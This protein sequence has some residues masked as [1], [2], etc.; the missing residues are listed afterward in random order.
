MIMQVIL[1]AN[2]QRFEMYVLHYYNKESSKYTSSTLEGLNHSQSILDYIKYMRIQTGKNWQHTLDV[3]TNNPLNVSLGYDN[4]NADWNQ[5][6]IEQK[7][8]TCMKERL[9]YQN[10][11]KI[12]RLNS[13][14]M[15]P[16]W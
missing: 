6:Q 16:H 3:S 10:R 2:D 11:T 8:I 7:Q 5:D 12:T 1:L 14:C 15:V 4:Q 9:K 13:W